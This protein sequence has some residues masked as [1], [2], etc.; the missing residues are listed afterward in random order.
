MITTQ[1]NQS[2]KLILKYHI[3]LTETPTVKTVGRV[4]AAAAELATLG[5]LTTKGVFGRIVVVIGTL[6]L[7]VVKEAR[8][9]PEK[10]F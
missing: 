9:L 6:P 10:G 7:V 4:P 2:S 1:L 3:H 5:V 8:D